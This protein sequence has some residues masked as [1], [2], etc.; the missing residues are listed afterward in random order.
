MKTF[1][2]WWTSL[3]RTQKPFGTAYEIVAK[4][5]WNAALGEAAK[6]AMDAEPQSGLH[7][8]FK[9]MQVKIDR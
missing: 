8:E 5:S 1:E 6:S 7:G 4:K 9:S 3:P 2:Q